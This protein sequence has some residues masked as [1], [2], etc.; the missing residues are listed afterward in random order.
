MTTA[1]P[2]LSRAPFAILS[3]PFLSPSFAP[4]A[5]LSLD[6]AS[7]PT[8]VQQAAAGSLAPLHDAAALDDPVDH[9]R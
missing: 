8:F 2:L 3:R 4:L 5:A 6:G 7:R 1:L 9:R